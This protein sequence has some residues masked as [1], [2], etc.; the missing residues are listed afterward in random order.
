MSLVDVLL[1]FPSLISWVCQCFLLKECER[2]LHY[3]SFSHFFKRKYRCVLLW[4]RGAL[5]GLASWRVRRAGDALNNWA[6]DSRYIK[7][8]LRLMS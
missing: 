1:K 3:K 8:I 5:G 2:L 7:Y 6:L 4:G